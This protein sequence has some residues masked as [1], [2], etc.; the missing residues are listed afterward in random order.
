VVQA[1]NDSQITEFFASIIAEHSHD[2]PPSCST[3]VIS[4][5]I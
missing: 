2:P 3:P 4:F 5:R 1:F